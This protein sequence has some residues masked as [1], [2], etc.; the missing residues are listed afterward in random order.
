M[1]TFEDFDI[2]IPTDRTGEVATTCPKCA[3]HRQKNPNAKC[4][5]VNAD[6]GVWHC[7][8]CDWSGTLKSGAD[9]PSNPYAWT[10]KVFRRPEYEAPVSA[11]DKMLEWFKG[12]G[13]PAKVVNRNRI[14]TGTVW[15]PQVEAEVT[16]IRFPSY[17]DG[18]VI[19]IKS[20]DHQKHFRMESGAE[21]ILYG[22]DD[23]AGHDTLIIVEGEID[24]LSIETAGFINCVSVPDGAPAPETK[25]YTNKFSFLEGCDEFLSGFKQIILAVDND[26][27]GQTLEEELARRLGRERCSRIQWPEGCKDANEVLVKHGRD[28]VKECIDAARPYPVAGL[29]EISD[30]AADIDRL[31]EHG[32]ESGV[33]TGWP[34][35]DKHYRPALGQFTVVTGVPSHGKSEVVDALLVNLARNYGWSAAIFSP[36]NQPL[37]LH[38]EKIAE[39]VIGKPFQGFNKMTL[40]EKETAK[41]W[42]GDRFIFILPKEDGLSVDSVLDLARVAILRKGVRSLVI[43][44]WNELD[45]SRPSHFTETEYISQALSKIRRFAR[46]HQVH[47]WLI[48]HPTKL[49]KENG[50]YPVPTLYDISGSAHWINKADFGLTVWRDVLAEGS[51]VQI[52]IQKVRF[53]SN[54]APGLVELQYDRN[55]GRYSEPG[56]QN[57]QHFSELIIDLD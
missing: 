10:P 22:M 37:V 56:S 19:N 8:H 31:Y 20:R 5:S 48:A 42:I 38:F 46:E 49:K 51:P 23:A 24:K 28:M 2:Q 11:S 43:D 17:R 6:K 57:Q 9:N 36:E 44:P 3:P 39:K 34:S 27:P 52:H 4:L 26:A 41:K 16:A 21:R 25:N 35:M 54:G 15:M 53:K 50:K 55:T 1:K 14:S 47:V 13:I 18:E 29:F 45:H 7:N 33:K 12:R 32:Q 40:A 30:F